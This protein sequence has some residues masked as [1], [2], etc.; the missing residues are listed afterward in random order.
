MN[1][2]KNSPKTNYAQLKADQVEMA[3][4]AMVMM[5]KAASK[6]LFYSVTQGA[7]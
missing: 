7:L 5:E 3:M 2:L 6:Q 1:R 4:M